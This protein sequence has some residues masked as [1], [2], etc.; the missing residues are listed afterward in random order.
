MPE[1]T[2]SDRADGPPRTRPTALVTGG[3]AGI[4]LAFARH[5]AADGYD[6]V[7]VARDRARLA[8]AAARLRA[9]HGVDVE[10]LPA[11]LSE[12]DQLQQVA[13]R[14]AGPDRP[15]DLLVN[16]AG[17]A[18]HQGFLRSDVGEQERLL[19]VHCRAVLVLTH[20]AGRAMAQRRSGAVINVS[21]VAAYTAG[22][23]YAAAKAWTTAFSEA[24]AIELGRHGVTVTALLP[25]Y[26]RT[27][28]IGDRLATRLPDWAFVDPDRLVRT[29]LADSRRGRALSV[30]TKRYRIAATVLRVA[31]RSLVRLAS[32]GRPLRRRTLR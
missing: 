32:G 13:D 29:A 12:R 26:V 28:L 21:S 30:P 7:L 17:F 22:G 9:D 3:S 2:T 8:D 25:G 16:N 14:V 1:Q 24:M 4:G 19:D 10:V 15:V 6:L 20:A 11:D 31:P 5:L 23:T 27:D 18:V